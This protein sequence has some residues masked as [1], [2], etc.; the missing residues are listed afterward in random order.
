MAFLVSRGRGARTGC[1]DSSD[2]CARQALCPVRQAP[3]A[4]SVTEKLSSGIAERVRRRRGRD[5]ESD[6]KG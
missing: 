4:G 3:R 6:G 5:E 1:P 2:R